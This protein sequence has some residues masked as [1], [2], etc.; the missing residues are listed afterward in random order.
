MEWLLCLSPHF[1]TELWTKWTDE[2]VESVWVTVFPQCL[3]KQFTC[4]TFAVIYH[5]PDADQRVLQSHIT[6]AIDHIRQAHPQP[7]LMLCGD[8]NKFPDSHLTKLYQLKQI[9]TNPT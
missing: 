2:N 8:F 6:H 7:G 3:L 1:R 4:L 5:P 9:V